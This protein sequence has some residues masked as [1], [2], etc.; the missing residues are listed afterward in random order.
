MKRIIFGF[1]FLFP[2]PPA[3]ASDATYQAPES[4][5]PEIWAFIDKNTKPFSVEQADLNGDGR[6]DVIL[7]LERQDV[8]ADEMPDN[9][10]PPG[11]RP[12]KTAGCAYCRAY[13]E[14]FSATAGPF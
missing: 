14:L 9:Q 13:V 2:A 5:P 6:D 8:A 4:L 3:L 12:G 7:V 1:L 11:L 10:R